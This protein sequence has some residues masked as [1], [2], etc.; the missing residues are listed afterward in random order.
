MPTFVQPGKAFCQKP[1]FA[2]AFARKFAAALYLSPA[3]CGE[4][5]RVFLNGEN[6]NKRGIYQA[7][8]PDPAKPKEVPSWLTGGRS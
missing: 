3:A 6:D 5:G 7:G 2:R 4:A 8:T 1:A